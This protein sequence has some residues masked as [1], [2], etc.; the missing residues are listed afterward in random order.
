VKLPDDKLPHRALILDEHL[1]KLAYDY[2]TRFGNPPYDEVWDGL[3][4]LFPLPDNEHQEIRGRF[5]MPFHEIE[6][7]YVAMGCNV[8]DRRDDWLPNYRCPDYV[9]YLEGTTA[10]ECGTHWCGGPDFLIEIVSPEE[11]P[12]EK[13]GFYAKVNAREV[14]IVDRYPWSLELYQLRDGAMQ[15]AGR[16][17]LDHPNVL[18]S[19]V[20]PLTFQLRKGKARPTILVTH[21]ATGQTWT[22]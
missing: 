1:I 20:V 15:L 14:L 19:H 8:S 21:A 18:A 9:V 2:R 12:R 7:K 22:A 13:L 11:N 4:V 16:S 6:S 5:C 10:E 3:L 17:D